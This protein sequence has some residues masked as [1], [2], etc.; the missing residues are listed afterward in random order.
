MCM[1]PKAVSFL[2]ARL[3]GLRLVSEGGPAFSLKGNHCR[4]RQLV[5]MCTCY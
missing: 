2:V 3:G 5:L 1:F 4:V